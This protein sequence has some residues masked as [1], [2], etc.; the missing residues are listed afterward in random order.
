MFLFF[1]YV[2]FLWRIFPWCSRNWKGAKVFSESIVINGVMHN[3]LYLAQKEMCVVFF[4]GGGIFHPEISGDGV[5]PTLWVLLIQT[6]NCK[7]CK[8]NFDQCFF[9][10]WKYTQYFVWHLPSTPPKKETLRIMGSQNWWFG[11]PR[12]LLYTSKPL[13]SRV[14]WF[15]RKANSCFSWGTDSGFGVRLPDSRLR[16][17]SCRKIES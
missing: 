2:D 17:T 10:P 5:G 7:I 14:Q 15:L 6:I 16:R 9:P 11:D 4:V 8:I 1:F 3:L 13:Y 12:P